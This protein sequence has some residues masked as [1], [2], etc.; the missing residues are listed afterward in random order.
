MRPNH[1]GTGTGAQHNKRQLMGGGGVHVT[2]QPPYG[3]A[4]V[5]P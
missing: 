2:F 1:H 5:I 3:F 4:P